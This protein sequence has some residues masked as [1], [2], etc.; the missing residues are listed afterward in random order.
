MAQLRKGGTPG[1]SRRSQ[2]GSGPR[3]GRGGHRGTARGARTKPVGPPPQGQLTHH[4]P[5]SR[6]VRAGP[7]GSSDGLRQG[8]GR[9]GVP[10]APPA[11]AAAAAAAVSGSRSPGPSAHRRR[12][13]FELPRPP[14]LLLA[15]AHPPALRWRLAAPL[16]S[17]AESDQRAAPTEIA[18]RPR[19]PRRAR[20]RPRSP[21]AAPGR[22]RTAG[23][24][25]RRSRPTSCFLPQ[26]LGAEG[27]GAESG[28]LERWGEGHVALREKRRMRTPLPRAEE[29]RPKK[30]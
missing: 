11:A 22:P 13:P 2:P 23:F 6:R 14:S 25:P 20:R 12:P 29:A 5:S 9:G 30:E 4:S 3:V 1:A 26:C 16:C 8:A 28:E 15:L 19:P 24:S 10:S 21:L 18:P 27:G 17:A 7:R